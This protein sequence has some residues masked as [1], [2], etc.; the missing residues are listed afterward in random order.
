KKHIEVAHAIMYEGWETNGNRVALKQ[1][2]VLMTT[3]PMNEFWGTFQAS[4]ANA[5]AL[6]DTQIVSNSD[7]GAGYSNEKFQ[8][9]FSQSSYPLLHQLDAYHVAQAINRTFGY[10][11]SE[12]KKNIKQ[13]LETKNLDGFHLWTDSYESTLEDEKKM[14]RLKQFRTYILNHWE[15]IG[16]WRERTKHVSQDAKKLGAMESNQRHISFRMKRRGM[17]WSQEGAESMVKVKQG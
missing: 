15:F 5:Y 6:E 17:H 16:D 1:R 2:Q 11:S 7:G 13:A 12:F 3:Q 10:K 14:E 9:A 8:E 4:A